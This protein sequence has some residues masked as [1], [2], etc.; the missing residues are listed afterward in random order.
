[1]RSIQA[2]TKKQKKTRRKGKSR[3][4][5][6]V[7][8]EKRDVYLE[9]TKGNSNK[10][11]SAELSKKKDMIFTSWGKIGTSASKHKSHKLG[12]STPFKNIQEFNKLVQSKLEKGYVRGGTDTRPNATL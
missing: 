1:M 2:K 10:F 7:T 11:W 4:S 9:Y 3:P 6:M 5:K 8:G 12:R